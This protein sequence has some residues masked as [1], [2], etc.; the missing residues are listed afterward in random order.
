M[1]KKILELESA[2]SKV[3]YPKNNLDFIKQ[4]LIDNYS[5]NAMTKIYIVTNDD[6]I[7]IFVIEYHLIVELN[8]KKYKLTV[9]VY[10]PVLFPKN[11]PE[12]YIKGVSNS[13]YICVSQRYSGKINSNDLRINLEY[14]MKYDSEKINISEIIDN[15]MVNFTYNFPVYKI[16]NNGLKV[17]G[18]CILD[19][20][21]A[22]M[23]NLP[24]K[25]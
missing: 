22:I 5:D 20:S 9:L 3:S 21:K 7:N 25:I 18:K 4:F 8:L 13:N 2:L 1:N 24:K 23:V 19:Y 16:E 14:F 6:G 12:F 15:L 10:L 11:A 17:S